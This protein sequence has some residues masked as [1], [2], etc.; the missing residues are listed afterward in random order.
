MDD[1]NPLGPP[2]APQFHITIHLSFNR[3]V[4]APTL[5]ARLL[6]AIPER[7]LAR[8]APVYNAVFVFLIAPALFGWLLATRDRPGFA[9][10]AALAWIPFLFIFA[11]LSGAQVARL[12]ERLHSQHKFVEAL[13]DDL[14]SLVSEAV[15]VALGGIEAGIKAHEEPIPEPEQVHQ[16]IARFMRLAR[17]LD[18][19]L[20]NTIYALE[21]KHIHADSL[22]ELQQDIRPL[23]KKNSH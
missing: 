5:L 2:P 4:G 6:L 10:Y 7:W 18:Q 12:V 1:T 15:A 8:I 11:T 17:E 23:L 14:S 13:E 22:R 21:A 16:L 9:F 20:P 3:R 19:R